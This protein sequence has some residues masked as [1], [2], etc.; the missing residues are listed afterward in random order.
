MRLLRIL[1][2]ICATAVS[3]YVFTR[4]QAV[5]TLIIPVVLTGIPLI[6]S[7][8]IGYQILAVIGL[9][10]FVILGVL[11]VGTFYVPSLL[12]LLVSVIL[13]GRAPKSGRG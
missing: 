1:A 13:Q 6:F 4:H 11:S 10:I 8:S 3:F 5:W 2:F 12:L 9:G 7:R